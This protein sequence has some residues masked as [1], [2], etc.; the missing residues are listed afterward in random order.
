MNFSFEATWGESKPLEEL[1][2]LAEKRMSLMRE[3]SYDAAVSTLINTLV[4]LRAL[5]R[6]A[7]PARKTKVIVEPVNQYVPSASKRGGKYQRCIRTRDGV[8][9]SGIRRLRWITNEM[10]YRDLHV[11][12]VTPEH[13]TVKPYLV[14]APS[15][16]VAED[17]EQNCA[18]RRKDNYGELAKTALGIAM[19][20][21]STRNVPTRRFARISESQIAATAETREGDF[22]T[23]EARDM[24]DYAA[25]ALP[26]GRS[27][28]NT[29]LMRAANKTQGILVNFVNK[30]G[31]RVFG[32][33]ANIGPTPFPEVLKRRKSA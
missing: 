23:I 27:D 22:V 21:L 17:F 3:T 16:A 11:Y 32:P 18:R 13:A 20:K 4:S 31:M 2:R 28:I 19:A 1:T 29:A 30:Y 24:L 25:A 9:I 5:T 6:R 12:R 15:A 8:H 10:P 26:H 33:E 14:V 7:R